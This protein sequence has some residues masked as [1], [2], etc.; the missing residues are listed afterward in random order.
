[1]SFKYSEEAKSAI[2]KINLYS[3]SG[4]I[5]VWDFYYYCSLIGMHFQKMCSE[6]VHLN[7]F[8]KN[9]T[10]QYYPYRH[11]IAGLLISTEIK[12][13]GCKLDKENIIK[14]FKLLISSDS[15]LILN[16]KG[17]NLLDRYAEGGFQIL[18]EKYPS[19]TDAFDFLTTCVSIIST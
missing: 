6:D 8:S 15:E 4:D 11:I 7:E 5:D 3:R 10:Q 9:Y 1:M 2:A 13:I 16:S 18:S 12:R 17:L 19:M 14:Q